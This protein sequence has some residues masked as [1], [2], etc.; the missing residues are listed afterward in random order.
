MSIIFT[1]EAEKR[2]QEAALQRRAKKS[3]TWELL[4]TTSLAEATH[5]AKENGW[6]KK[7]VQVRITQ[8]NAEEYEYSVEPFERDCTCPNILKYMDYF[9]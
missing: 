8:I 3:I 6:K 5:F 1:A 4:T 7:K 9:D 2:R